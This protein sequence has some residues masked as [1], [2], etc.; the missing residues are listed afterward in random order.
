[1]RLP[2]YRSPETNESA[3]RS[4]EKSVSSQSDLR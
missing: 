2:Q 3:R 4:R 1:M